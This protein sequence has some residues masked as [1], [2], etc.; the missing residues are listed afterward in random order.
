MQYIKQYINHRRENGV[1]AYSSI[2]GEMGVSRD[3]LYK[4]RAGQRGLPAY[5]AEEMAKVTGLSPDYWLNL[6]NV[7]K[8]KGWK[9]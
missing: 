3:M 5:V 6:Y 8:Y 2:A 9:K 1:K 4:M 7:E